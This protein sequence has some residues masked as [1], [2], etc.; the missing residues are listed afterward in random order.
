MKLKLVFGLL[1][2]IRNEIYLKKLKMVDGCIK[3]AGFNFHRFHP[4]PPHL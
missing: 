3:T 4:L 1:T 2:A